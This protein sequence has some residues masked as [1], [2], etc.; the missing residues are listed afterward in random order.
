M[1]DEIYYRVQQMHY[2]VSKGRASRRYHTMEML[3][4]QRI[5]AHSYGVAMYTVMLVPNT[6]AE[7]RARLLMAALA[8]DLPEHVTG[9]MP[10]P[11]KRDYPEVRKTLNDYEDKALSVIGLRYQ[12][13]ERDTRVLKLADALDGA[14]HCTVERAKGN[15]FAEEPFGNFWEYLKELQFARADYEYC[16]EGERALRA[17]LSNSWTNAGGQW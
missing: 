2:F 6:T 5:D 11:F 17:T 16:E 4:Y 15:V 13:D 1:S 3:E 8:H 12:L 9:D 7:R 10:A 14:Y